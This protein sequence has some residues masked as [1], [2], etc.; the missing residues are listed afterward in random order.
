M[1]IFERS[2]TLN[3]E[4]WKTGIGKPRTGRVRSPVP[5]FQIKV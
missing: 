3:L 2:Q 5:E 4:L 1:G